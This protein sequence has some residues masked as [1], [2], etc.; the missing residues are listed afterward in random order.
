MTLCLSFPFTLPPPAGSSLV[1]RGG[2]R[3]VFVLCSVLAICPVLVSSCRL[4][5]VAYALGVL[6]RRVAPRVSY[7]LSPIMRLV[8]RLVF[9][10]GGRLVVPALPPMC[11]SCLFFASFS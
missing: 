8:G 4:V 6:L 10:L 1:G 11:F 9:H 7:L 5:G 2:E 3:A